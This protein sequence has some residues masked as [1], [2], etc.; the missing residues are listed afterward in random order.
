MNIKPAIIPY[1]LSEL[2]TK[3]DVFKNQTDWV[4][5]DVVDGNFATGA[6]WNNP[7]DLELIDGRAKI[8]V[9]LMVEKPEDVVSSWVT[10]VDRLIMHIESTDH[11]DVLLESLQH[12]NIKIGLALLLETPLDQI[13]PYLQTKQIDLVQL[14]SIENIGHHGEVFSEATLEKIKNLREM[15][16]EGVIQVDGGIN[17]EIVS[18]VLAAGASSVVVGSALWNSVDP[19]DTFEQFK[20][21]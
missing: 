4:H 11:L 9:H 10:V 21:I 2:E 8:E 14:M 17:L 20:K 13:E 18:E 19:V 15:W 6:S 5:L 7:I 16:P 1:T 12:T 3:M